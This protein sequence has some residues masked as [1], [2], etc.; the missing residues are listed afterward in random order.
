MLRF[1]SIALRCTAA[2]TSTAK[3]DNQANKR[4]KQFRTDERKA[5]RAD[6]AASPSPAPT[7]RRPGQFQR[8]AQSRAGD[9][10]GSRMDAETSEVSHPIP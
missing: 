8:R 2:A 1:E 5:A 4:Q 9:E 7:E 10:A 6:G 3:S